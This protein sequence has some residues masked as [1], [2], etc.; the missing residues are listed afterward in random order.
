MKVKYRNFRRLTD[1]GAIGSDLESMG[2]LSLVL[3][4]CLG[5]AFHLG[6]SPVFCAILLVTS[7][8]CFI[9]IVLSLLGL[10]SGATNE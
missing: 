10:F 4:I 6:E 5:L 3:F 2:I 8:V 9:P 1:A 7:V